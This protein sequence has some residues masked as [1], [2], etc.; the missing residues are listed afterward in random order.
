[1]T[2]TPG[3]PR[4]SGERRPSP[5]RG[6]GAARPPIRGRA[7][8]DRAPRSG[9]S[10]PGPPQGGGR[11]A[12]PPVRGRARGNKNQSTPSRSSA[13][14]W[15]ARFRRGVGGRGCGPGLW[16]DVCAC[17]GS[18]THSSLLS[19]VSGTVGGVRNRSSP[20]ADRAR[21]G[22]RASENYESYKI[23]F[24]HVQMCALLTLHESCLHTFV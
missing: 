13:P 4:R 11:V 14:C 22:R 6:G 2:V 7:Y 8:T 21:V 17:E 1:M 10:R 15:L 19:T 18:S 24:L 23:Y 16:M 12:R 5:P 3:P 20:P 9:G